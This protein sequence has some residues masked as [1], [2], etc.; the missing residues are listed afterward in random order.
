MSHELQQQLTAAIHDALGQLED[1][2]GEGNL[3]GFA[4]CTDDS[5]GSLY[6]VASST[7]WTEAKDHLKSAVWPP[8]WTARVPD[9]SAFDEISQELFAAADKP[10]STNAWSKARDA[11]FE[12][13]V[14]TM[15]ELAE[16]GTF[17][18]FSYLCVTSTSPG[19]HMLALTRDAIER[20]NKDEAYSQA[21]REFLGI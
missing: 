16:A 9:K 1:E 6:P 20:L 14:Q 11:R 2:F 19:N 18:S 10:K 17:E 8:E 12:L 13:L 5:V 7:S 3:Y 4:L 15:L 21:F